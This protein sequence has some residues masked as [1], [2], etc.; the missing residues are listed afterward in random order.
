[1]GCLWYVT[2]IN[3]INYMIYKY[4]TNLKIGQK[5]HTPLKWLNYP[6]KMPKTLMIRGHSDVSIVYYIK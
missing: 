3:I 6:I 2:K 5:T 4:T 1:M